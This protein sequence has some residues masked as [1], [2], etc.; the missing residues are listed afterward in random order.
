MFLE[1]TPT[2]AE[3]FQ[4]LIG[5]LATWTGW[6]AEFTSMIFGALSLVAILLVVAGIRV[7]Q[8]RSRRKYSKF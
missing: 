1:A 7:Q 5:T 2:A 6:T 8:R 4:D 3:N